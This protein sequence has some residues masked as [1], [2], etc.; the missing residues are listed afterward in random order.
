MTDRA[1]VNARPED[2]G[3]RVRVA[4]AEIEH[5]DAVA[6]LALAD[7]RSEL[8]EPVDRGPGESHDDVALAQ[9][10]AL[11]AGAG[12]HAR[13]PEPVVA[14]AG[15]RDDAEERAGRAA[16]LA[17]T[18]GRPRDLGVDGP[19]VAREP[20]DDARADGGDARHAARVELVGGVTRLVAVAVA[21]GVE[22]EHR[23]S[24]RVEPAVIGGTVRRAVDLEPDALELRRVA[25][26]RAYLSSDVGAA[27]IETASLQPADHVEVHHR[28]GSIERDDGP[29]HVVARADQPELLG[30][31]QGED[32]RA[33]GAPGGR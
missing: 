2:R 5:R 12:H 9:P 24:R 25:H 7:Q 11:G 20:T 26:D 14:G 4:V 10:R 8:L 17:L 15:E 23:D 1:L 29:V 21:A 18:P 13:Q 33:A 19:R 31:E 6:G 16:A 27:D 32:Q 30:A 28:D 3:R 22:E